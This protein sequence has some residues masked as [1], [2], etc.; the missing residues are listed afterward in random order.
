MVQRDDREVLH[1]DACRLAVER[2]PLRE[3]ERLQRLCERAGLPV[4][5]PR[6]GM[7]RYLELMRVDKKAEG[8]EIRFVVID[9]LGRA[10]MRPAPDALVADVIRAHAAP[11]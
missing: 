5:G 7:E 9:G 11:G 6:L 3:V 1:R 10:A 8:G 2:L 4:R